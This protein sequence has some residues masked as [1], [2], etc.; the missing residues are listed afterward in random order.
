MQTEQ[1]LCWS[2]VTD[3]ETEQST[4]SGSN[5]EE[6]AGRPGVYAIAPLGYD[7]K[8][9]ATA[10]HTNKASETKVEQMNKHLL[11]IE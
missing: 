1:L 8:R 4:T 6:A 10:A 11:K 9:W 7:I 2:G 3:T 5:K